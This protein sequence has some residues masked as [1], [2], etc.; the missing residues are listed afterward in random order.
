MWPHNRLQAVLCEMA[1]DAAYAVGIWVRRVRTEPRLVWGSERL[2]RLVVEPDEYGVDRSRPPTA[3]E[4]IKDA[5]RR[6]AGVQ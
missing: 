3:A 2:I 5:E 1:L 4:Q 6:T